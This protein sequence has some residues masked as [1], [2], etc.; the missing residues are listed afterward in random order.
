[1]RKVIRGK[2]YD[3]E[4]AKEVGS[5]SN[6]AWNNDYFRSTLYRKRT[7]E[8]FRC[9]QFGEYNFDEVIEPVTFEQAREWAECHL[10]GDEYIAEFGTPAEGD[11]YD[12][13]A[14]VSMAAWQAMSRAAA[15]EGVTVGAII[16]RLASTL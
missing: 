13:H 10:D 4:K 15:A 2:L 6:G 3:T 8:Y 5:W 1:M 16:E 14:T 9:D 11:R 12:L 7:G